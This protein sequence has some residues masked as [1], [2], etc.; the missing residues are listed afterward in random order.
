MGIMFSLLPRDGN[1]MS[2]DTELSQ[3]KYHRITDLASLWGLEV[4]DLLR[5]ALEGS[6]G[7]AI[8]EFRG[9]DHQIEAIDDG[10][11]PSWVVFVPPDVL[12]KIASSGDAYV[13]GGFRFTESEA[14]PVFFPARRLLA[15]DLIVLPQALAELE[16]LLGREADKN[17]MHEPEMSLASRGTL[18]KQIAALAVLLSK[19]QTCFEWG[20]RPNSSK[21]ALE[22]GRAI[23]NWPAGTLGKLEHDFFSKSKINDSIR[24]GLELIGF[25]EAGGGK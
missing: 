1:Y 22:I 20:E 5:M 19:Q 3:R 21:I 18:L 11:F 13:S 7:I 14:K 12:K 10:A 4:R 2:D 6:V 8:H 16:R 15:E 17:V 25:K 24:E 23:A 9:A